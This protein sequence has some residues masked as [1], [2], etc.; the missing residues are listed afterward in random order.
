MQI[1]RKMRAPLGA[2]TILCAVAAGSLALGSAASE[3]MAAKRHISMQF[4]EHMLKCE[5]L[6]GAAE[7]ACERQAHGWAEVAKAELESQRK[8]ARQVRQ[9]RQAREG[10][11][12]AQLKVAQARCNALPGRVRDR[13]A[14]GA[15]RRG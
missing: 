1:L 3:Q 8:G 6:Q 11:M 13:C 7:Q 9:A 2:C 12:P 15:A 4:R 10:G 5:H 14:D